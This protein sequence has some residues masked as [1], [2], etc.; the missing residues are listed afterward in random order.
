[1]PIK[2]S[3]RVVERRKRLQISLSESVLHQVDSYA[4]Y[5]GG[6]SDRVYVIEQI[7]QA[8]FEQEKDFQRWLKDNS[9]GA[10]Q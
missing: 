6:N 2:I 1:M 9:G 3:P 5:L 4:K 10:R 8:F 7:L